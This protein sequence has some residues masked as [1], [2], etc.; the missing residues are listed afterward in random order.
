MPLGWGVSVRDT[1]SSQVVIEV[2]VLVK[3]RVDRAIGS[4]LLVVIIG[5]RAIQCVLRRCV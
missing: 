3:G 5:C 2:A 1:P 4:V